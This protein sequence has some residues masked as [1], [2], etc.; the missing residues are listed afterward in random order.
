MRAL[1]LDAAQSQV[2]AHPA[3]VKSK[4]FFT[5]AALLGTKTAMG[6]IESK[7]HVLLDME[8]IKWSVLVFIDLKSLS[9]LISN[10][11]L[12]NKRRRVFCVLPLE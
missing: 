12:R 10:M 9:L 4:L 3:K 11:Q 1:S 8:S 2:K 6:K 7:V 5:G